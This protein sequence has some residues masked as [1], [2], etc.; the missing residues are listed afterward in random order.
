[1]TFTAKSSNSIVSNIPPGVAPVMST[2]YIMGQM[3]YFQQPVYSY[4]EMQMLQQRIPH[5]VSVE[6]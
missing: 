5:M 3:Q 2:P 1:M 6:F 4:E